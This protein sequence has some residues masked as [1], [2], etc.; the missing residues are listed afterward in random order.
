MKSRN[1]NMPRI[2]VTMGDANGVGPEIIAEAL[3]HLRDSEIANWILV[4]EGSVFRAA[5]DLLELPMDF[6]SVAPDALQEYS[7]DAWSVIPTGH[8]LEPHPGKMEKDSAKAAHAALQIAT[9]LCLDGAAAGMVTAPISKEAFHSIGITFPGQTELLAHGAKVDKTVMCFIAGSLR[10]AL[11]TTHLAIKDVS[12]ALSV[13]HLSHTLNVLHDF[14]TT[15]LRIPDPLI[16]VCAL[17]PHAGEGGILGTEENDIIL[18]VIRRMQVRG[19][20]I[21]GPLAAD[22]IFQHAESYE[23]ILAMYHDQG[24]IP[25]KR[26]ARMRA[27][28][29]TLGLPFVRT[30]PDHGTAF[31]IAWTGKVDPTSMIEAMTLAVDLIT[32]HGRPSIRK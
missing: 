18:P 29:V 11:A 30:S 10:V 31:D 15:G 28:N 21:A 32:K 5:A 20:R 2:A 14:L 22:V 12:P 23:A 17:N 25:V 3:W 19:I 9:K 4:G 26:I 7:S 27:V 13:E 24:M 1:K 16:G 8:A 6:Q